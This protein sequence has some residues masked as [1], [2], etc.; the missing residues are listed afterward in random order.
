MLES[1]V[2]MLKVI[3]LAT[4]PHDGYDPVTNKQNGRHDTSDHYIF[5]PLT[6]ITSLLGI[7]NRD[8]DGL[9][10]QSIGNIAKNMI[11]W[12]DNV[13]LIRKL[14]NIL[15]IIPTTA[16]H[17]C[18]S[19]IRFTTNLAK[20][21]T[22]FFPGLVALYTKFAA[23]R[24][25]EIIPEIAPQASIT[26]YGW[27]HVKR[28]TLWSI[29]LFLESLH[30]AADIAFIIGRA[31]TSP[32]KS[33]R[34]GWRRGLEM[35][36]DNWLGW[37]IGG[38]LATASIAITVLMYALILPIAEKYA[39]AL[40]VPH[41]P[42]VAMIAINHTVAFTFPLLSKIGSTIFMPIVKPV[43]NALNITVSPAIV[44][45]SAF[46]GVAI[47]TV[48]TVTSKLI[49]DFKNWW[50]NCAKREVQA[51]AVHHAD[52]YQSSAARVANTIPKDIQPQKAARPEQ[53]SLPNRA[54]YEITPLAINKS[55]L[56]G[57]TAVVSPCE[58]PKA[59]RQTRLSH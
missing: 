12:E 28:I 7:P 50:F 18:V 34:I 52:N 27:H 48:G 1:L 58:E 9:N 37:L 42:A 55:T 53:V 36:G 20:L 6:I 5:H 47:T 45:M 8:L 10:E 43:F 21:V 2:N 14:F 13:S 31:V 41:L 22:E 40:I 33:V 30:Y 35:A 11:G 17:L 56:Y 23:Y 16:W 19:V 32:H 46:A 49:D 24:I 29:Y 38:V 51:P 15:K 39:L 44:T 54:R 26:S 4:F 3:Y 25:Y 59:T 57:A